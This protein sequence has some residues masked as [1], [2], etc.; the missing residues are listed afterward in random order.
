MS[1][2]ISCAVFAGIRLHCYISDGGE[3]MDLLQCDL[4]LSSCRYSISSADDDDGDE[5]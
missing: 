3:L 4:R 5:D 1:A 2:M